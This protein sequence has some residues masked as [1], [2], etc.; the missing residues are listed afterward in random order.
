MCHQFVA[1]LGSRIQ[2]DWIVYLVVC[3]VWHLDIAAV[4]RGRTCIY[5]VLDT[6]VF[7]L[8]GQMVAAGFQDVVEPDDVALYVCIRIGDGVAYARLCGKVYHYGDVFF[9]EES[10]HKI[11]VSN[12]AFHEH[13]FLLVPFGLA[14]YQGVY[15]SQ[16]LCLYVH[17]V[18]VGDGVY[19]YYPYPFHIL[20]DS[21][22]KVAS[23]E[24]GSTS[25]QDCLA[26]QI[27]VLF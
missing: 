1:L 26:F 7:A 5:Q 12:R 27:D 6:S 17:V 3:A 15:F 22:D 13:P 20:K 21:L 4:H 25:N 14:A 8:L 9:R 10:V 24:S 2:G 19:S 23:D 18:V 11:P 16:T